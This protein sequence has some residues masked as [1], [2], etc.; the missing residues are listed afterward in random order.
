MKR[1]CEH[2][3]GCDREASRFFPTEP[4]RGWLCEE[5]FQQAL[6]TA[7]ELEAAARAMPDSAD[8][9]SRL[10][11]ERNWQLRQENILPLEA[12]WNEGRFYGTVLKGSR[13]LTS[14]QR[15]GIFMLSLSILGGGLMTFIF[16][17]DPLAGPSLKSIHQRL[18]RASLVWAPIIFLEIAFAIR[19]CWVAI[20][21]PPH[22]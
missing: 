20:K 19:L 14:V 2:V 4:E 17:A 3:R 21:R 18:P 7:A 13:P 22:G 6:E 9:S 10:E 12:A 15:I 8:D 5:H 1:R 11:M 16:G